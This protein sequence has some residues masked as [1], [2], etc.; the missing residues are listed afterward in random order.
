MLKSLPRRLQ[1]N[2]K[3]CVLEALTTLV[4]HRVVDQLWHFV[5]IGNSNNLDFFVLD[6]IMMPQSKIDNAA[7]QEFPETLFLILCILKNK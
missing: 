4:L 6:S 1:Y 3:L 7:K 5:I 2:T